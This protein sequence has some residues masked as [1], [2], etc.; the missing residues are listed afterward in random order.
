MELRK[1]NT[2]LVVYINGLWPV[3]IEYGSSHCALPEVRID[4][5]QS[6]VWHLDLYLTINFFFFSNRDP[7]VVSTK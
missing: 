6:H 3:L 1:V 4:E 7:Q 2:N 5:E